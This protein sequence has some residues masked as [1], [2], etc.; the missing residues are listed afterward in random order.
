MISPLLIRKSR[1]SSVQIA[2]FSTPPLPSSR[3]YAYARIMSF[4]K[5]S[6]QVSPFRDYSF[7]F[8]KNNRSKTVT[9]SVTL[10]QA[11]SSRKPLCL[12][13]ISAYSLHF[14]HLSPFFL[15][16]ITFSSFIRHLFLRIRWFYAHYF[17]FSTHFLG[18]GDT[19][20][21]RSWSQIRHNSLITNTHF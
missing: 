5:K 2:L 13:G 14:P 3:A 18:K 12:S 16:S 4:F 8:Q 1:L 17:P 7:D 9:P 19:W 6:R 15:E 21:D 10:S 11:I 20:G